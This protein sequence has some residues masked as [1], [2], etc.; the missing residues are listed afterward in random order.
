MDLDLQALLQHLKMD[1]LD[2]Q[3]D[4]L[5]EQAAAR[6]MDYKSFLREALRLEWQ[7]RALRSIA[8]RLK[9]ARLPWVKTLE[10]FEFDFQP[11]LDKHQIRELAGLSFVERAHNLVL[12]GRPAWARRIWPS[13]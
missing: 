3:L 9:Q 5:C 7:G 8:W 10:Q 11:S 6:D 4:T 2:S 1:H 12:L 13:P